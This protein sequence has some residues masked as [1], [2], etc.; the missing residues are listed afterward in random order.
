MPVV[1]GTAKHW[2]ERAEEARAMAE[3]MTDP[4]A[5]SAMLTVADSYEKLAERAEARMA[6]EPIGGGDDH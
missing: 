6:K 3:Q 5:K 2:R 1:F 4:A